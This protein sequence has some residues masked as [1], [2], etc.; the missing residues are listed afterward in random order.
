MKNAQTKAPPTTD[1]VTR[2][3][4]AEV[5]EELVAVARRN[6]CELLEASFAGGVLKLILDRKEGVGLAHCETVSREASAFLDVV[7]F[8]GGRYTLEVSSPGLD[9][10]L[11]SGGDYERFRG[12]A[13]RITWTDSGRKRTDEAVLVGLDPSGSA[14]TFEFADGTRTVPFHD[15]VQTRLDPQF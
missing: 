13:V 4:P 3:V 7:D 6:D 9:R 8:G 14:A 11:Y 1:P 15:I 10:E 12:S 5:C 2:N